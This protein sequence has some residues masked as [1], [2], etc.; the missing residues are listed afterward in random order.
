[1]TARPT[2]I[3]RMGCNEVTLLNMTLDRSQRKIAVV[4]LLLVTAFFLFCRKSSEVKGAELELNFSES[5]LSDRLVV[6]VQYRWKTK[7]NFA[8]IDQ[9]CHI[10]VHFWHRNNLILHDN[11][12]PE[13]PVPQWEPDKEYVYSRRI[14]I[15]SFIDASDP[16]FKGEETIKLSIGF[17]F[18]PGSQA[19]LL[20]KVYERKIKF[21]PPPPDT[22]E[23]IYENGWYDFE[24]NPEDFLK[25]WRWTGKEARCLIDNPHRDALLILRGGIH[26]KADY[27]Q[28]VIFRLNDMVLDEFIPEKRYFE[29]SYDVKKGMLG[30]GSKFHL[31]ISVDKTFIPAQAIPGSKDERELG[32]K[33]SFIYFR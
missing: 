11:H 28:K 33:I 32:M 22:P 12:V 14:Y 24:I 10:F 4:L 27:G 7:N 18:P 2:P 17:A 29:K 6:D 16:E 3:K 13:I 31:V 26:F 30:K 25:K 23:I 1:M 21:M 8:G 5:P 20:W 19:K 15:P 9:K